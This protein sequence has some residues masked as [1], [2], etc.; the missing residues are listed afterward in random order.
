MSTPP[1]CYFIVLE[2]V[3]AGDV[4]AND[5]VHDL[6]TPEDAVETARAALAK[7]P[8]PTWD[9]NEWTAWEATV[10]SGWFRDDRGE[11]I[12][13]ASWDDAGVESWEAWEIIEVIYKPHPE[14]PPG[15]MPDN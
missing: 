2:E 9:G 10:W 15:P 3:R 13:D 12:I 11:P 7:R 8:E 14:G 5:V 1:L 6:A 4:R